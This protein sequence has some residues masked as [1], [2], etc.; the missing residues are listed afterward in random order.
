MRSAIT[1]CLVPQARQ[2]PF[3]FHNGLEDGC[4]KA[5][6]FGF[7][8]VEIFPLAADLIDRAQLKAL[9]AQHKLAVAAF[10]TGGG[11]LV[12]QWSLSSPKAETR[13]QAREFIRSIIELAA[14]FG[15]PAILGSM[16]GK[17]E[18]SMDR[19]QA[20][21]WLAQGLEE[22]SEHAARFGQPLL[23]EALN[24]YE[25]NFFNRQAD[26]AAF[27]KTLKTKNAKLLC[28]L[29]HM[30]IEEQNLSE[31]IKEVGSLIGHVHFADSN[32]HAMG[33]GHTDMKP[34]YA[35]LKSV[36][37][38]GYLSA[39]VLPLPDSDSAAK[40]TIAAFKALEG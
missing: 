11:M 35:A 16:Q 15:A 9:L 36:G 19:Q 21:A 6:A 7:D 4:A 28:D 34:I 33:F 39:E 30:N 10:G 31:T 25:S 17:I 13:A 1:I 38:Q 14:A 22:L 20:L 2:G 40:Q 27:V 32:R 37:F 8:A 26:A 24:R 12:H 5:A 29:Y 18:P 3:V 23:F